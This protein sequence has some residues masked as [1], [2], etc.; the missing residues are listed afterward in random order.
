[1]DKKKAL[2]FGIALVFS[3]LFCCDFES[4]DSFWMGRHQ[5]GARG[6]LLSIRCFSFSQ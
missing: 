4:W 3:I 6:F 5:E 1:M 2:I